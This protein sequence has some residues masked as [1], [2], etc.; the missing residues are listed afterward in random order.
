MRDA[1][2]HLDPSVQPYRTTT[3]DRETDIGPT[4]YTALAQRKITK[5]KIRM[6]VTQCYISGVDHIMYNFKLYKIYFTV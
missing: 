4:A 3:C 2:N 5:N 1:K 6:Y